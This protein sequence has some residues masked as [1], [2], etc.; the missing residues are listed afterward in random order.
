[1]IVVRNTF[2]AKPGQASKLLAQMKELAIAGN[3]RNTRFL[4]DCAGDFNQVVME[5]EVESL[6]DFEALMQRYGT[7]PQI[8]DKAKGYTEYWL[9]GKRELFRMA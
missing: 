9:T 7:D 8:R 5:H 3:L 1:M 6:A 4:T 2:T